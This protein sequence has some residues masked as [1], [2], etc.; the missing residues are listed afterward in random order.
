MQVPCPIYKKGWCPQL[1]PTVFV[2]TKTVVTST[3][4]KPM[5]TGILQTQIKPLAI[6]K[7]RQWFRMSVIGVVWCDGWPGTKSKW[8]TVV[9]SVVGPSCYRSLHHCIA[10]RVTSLIYRRARLTA[11]NVQYLRC[12]S[13]RKHLKPRDWRKGICTNLTDFHLI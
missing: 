8:R 3:T 5:L 4:H 13:T 1:E 12:V 9:I 11:P 10:A 2:G 7:R 6:N